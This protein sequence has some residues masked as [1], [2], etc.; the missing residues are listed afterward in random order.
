MRDQQLL[1]D[2]V[3]VGVLVLCCCGMLVAAGQPRN[4]LF[5]GCIATLALFSL[6]AAAKFYATLRFRAFVATCTALS[7]CVLA[8]LLGEMQSPLLPRDPLYAS[9]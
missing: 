2:L 1:L 8:L 5:V 4:A 6:S 7:V 3:G 9:T